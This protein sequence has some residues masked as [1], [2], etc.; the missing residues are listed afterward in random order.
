MHTHIHTY[1][2]HVFSRSTKAMG[3]MIIDAIM[4]GNY[5]IRDELQ[6]RPN[7]IQHTYMHVFMY[8]PNTI[9]YTYMHVFMYVY[10]H[11]HLV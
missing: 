4:T 7:T 3:V 8:T 5:T 2:Q 9:K 1:T 11:V 6:V 10:M